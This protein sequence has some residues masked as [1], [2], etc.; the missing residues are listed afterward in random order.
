MRG[1][2]SGT[3]H[4]NL[5]PL[6]PT[7]PSITS[8]DGIALLWFLTCW[9][10]Y[11]F[12]ADHRPRQPRSLMRA[13]HANRARWMGRMLERDNRM[14]DT[15]I[16]GNLLR[17]V[18]FFASTTIFILGGLIAVFGAADTAMEVVADLP[19]AART[20]RRLW[21]VKLL[22]LIV[23]FAYAFF[24]F[25][26][27]LRQ[28]N[29]CSIMIGGAPPAGRPSEHDTE[30][31]RRVAAVSS[32]AADHFNRGLRAYYFGLAALSWFVHPALFIAASGWVVLVLYRREFRSKALKA[33]ADDDARSGAE[34][35]RGQ[36]RA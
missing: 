12:F 29:Y 20:S 10:G 23:I 4:R 5:H 18:T 35:G 21:K 22:L 27:S 36:G 24:K 25:T 19:L 33:L 16:V 32:L 17:I 8:L 1:P 11:T 26:W 7:V 13:M 34:A 3:M 15:G 30:Y 14:V 9:I 2:P 6:R 31:A 28:F